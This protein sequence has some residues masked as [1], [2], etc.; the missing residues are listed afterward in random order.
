MSCALASVGQSYFVLDG[1]DFF[2]GTRCATKD[3][4]SIPDHVKHN[5]RKIFGEKLLV[6]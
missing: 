2:S 6:D 5:R 1:H 4:T 3:L